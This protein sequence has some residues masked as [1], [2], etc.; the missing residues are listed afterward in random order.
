MNT[1]VLFFDTTTAFI[2]SAIKD[3]KAKHPMYSSRWLADRIGL[4]SHTI[5]TD[6]KHGR[7]K[8]SKNIIIKIGSYLKLNSSEMEYLEL[9]HQLENPTSPEQKCDIQMKI[10]ILRKKLSLNFININDE[11]ITRSPLYCFILESLDIR[12]L[13]SNPEDLYILLKRKFTVE[14]IRN[15]IGYLLLKNYLSISENNTLVKQNHN[16][17]FADPGKS[18]LAI[19]SYHKKLCQLASEAISESQI[20]ERAFSGICLN[21]DKLKMDEMK[22]Y[23]RDFMDEFVSKFC[24]SG[25]TT[26]ETYQLSLQFFKAI[27]KINLQ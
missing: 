14:E 2:L 3:L 12:P 15:T 6:I 21:V 16:N 27:E 25:K 19:Q 23:L 10:D 20:T 5:L 13:P 1:S 18:N 11:M 17:F 7:R 26:S 4:S 8:A 24:I 9:L 22:Q